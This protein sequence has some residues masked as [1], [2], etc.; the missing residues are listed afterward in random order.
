MIKKIAKW[1]LWQLQREMTPSRFPGL[2]IF[3]FRFTAEGINEVEV[4]FERLRE[5]HVMNDKELNW[6][7]DTQLSLPHVAVQII[8]PDNTLVIGF[9]AKDILAVRDYIDKA[10]PEEV[11]DELY[12]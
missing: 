12:N 2:K 8:E 5:K 9:W 10:V 1:K 6:W 11:E 3:A 4:K 7:Q